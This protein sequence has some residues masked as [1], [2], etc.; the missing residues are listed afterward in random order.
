LTLCLEE[1]KRLEMMENNVDALQKR[2][3]EVEGMLQRTVGAKAR[4]ESFKDFSISSE[5]PLLQKF[6]DFGID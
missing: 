1:K 6:K 3:M 4:H 2:A 5:D